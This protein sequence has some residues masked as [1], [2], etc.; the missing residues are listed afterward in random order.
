MRSLL[1]GLVSRIPLIDHCTVYVSDIAESKRF[2]DLALGAV[3]FGG[4]P[5]ETEGFAEWDEF[6]IKAAHNDRPAAQGLHIAFAAPSNEHVDTFWRVLTDAGYRDNGP[7]GERPEW[8]PGYYG[9]FVIDPDGHN[10]E[11][12]CHNR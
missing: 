7:P 3:E 8:H 11:A 9:A 5:F 10:G 4:T 12:V 6:S 1:L 2:Y